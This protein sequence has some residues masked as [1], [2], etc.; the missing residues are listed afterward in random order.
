MKQLLLASTALTL[1]GQALAADL[2]ARMPV[3]APVAAVSHYSWTGCYVGGHIGAG[4]GRTDISEPTE[5]LGFQFFA[6][7]NS[8]IGVDTGAGVLG[9]AQVG[10]DYQFATSW[11]VGLRGDFSW[12]NIS[13]LADDPFFAG[14]NPGPITLTAKTDRIA[15]AEARIGYAWDRWMLYGTGGPA[16]AHNKYGIQNLT[17]FGNP[18]NI[19]CVGGGTAIPCNPTG[20]DTRLGWTLG[21]GLEWAFAN[22]WTAGLEYAH[23]DFGSRSVT[24]NDYHGDPFIFV[25]SGPVDVKQQIDTVKLSISY[26]FGWPGVY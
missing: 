3:K 10:C 13:G 20:S 1:G 6:P 16:W 2:P 24:L 17:I 4:W 26:H 21:I 25:A 23:Y 19:F 18:N 12:A 14:K 15:S 8:P 11:V 9:G 22:S 7:A 5:P